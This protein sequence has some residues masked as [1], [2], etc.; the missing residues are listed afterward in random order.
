[1]PPF[2]CERQLAQ[3]SEVSETS[4]FYVAFLC[5]LASLREK[6]GYYLWSLAIRKLA[7]IMTSDFGKAKP[8]RHSKCFPDLVCCLTRYITGFICQPFKIGISQNKQGTW[9]YHSHYLMMIKR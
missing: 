1:M 2:A 5:G 4:D 8:F 7:M 6:T 3:K 9:R